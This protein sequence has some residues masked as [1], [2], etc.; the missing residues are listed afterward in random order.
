MVFKN[1]NCKDTCKDDPFFV[2][3]TSII[4]THSIY[5]LNKVQRLLF[6]T[7]NVTVGRDSGKLVCTFSS[8]QTCN[9]GILMLLKANKD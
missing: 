7:G 4:N 9:Y 5:V 1:A 8:R 2:H 6:F 3:K